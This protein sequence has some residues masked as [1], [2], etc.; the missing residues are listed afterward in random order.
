M[1]PGVAALAAWQCGGGD[2]QS[3]VTVKTRAT[4]PA[5]S[6]DDPE[7]TP[8]PSKPPEIDLSSDR[9]FQGGAALLS[10]IGDVSEGSVTFLE[11]KQ[12]LSQGA[13]SIYAFIPIDAEDPPGNHEFKVEF[14]LLSGSKG[15]ITGQIEV[16]ATRWTTDSIT[17][18]AR[19]SIILDPRFAAAEDE[20]LR[21]VYSPVSPDKLWEGG[22]IMP[23]G[24][25]VT[26]HFGEQ[27]SYNGGE[28]TGHHKGTDIGAP[29]GTPV[30]VTNNGRVVLARQLQLRGNT[31]VVDHGGGV[32]SSYAHLASFA[33]GEGEELVQGDVVG[34]LGST[35]LSTGAH[36]HWEMATG[37]I[38]VDAVRFVDGSNG[39]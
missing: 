38:P 23:T 30:S 1:V 29:E 17:L 22:W 16:M 24:G 10:L 6:L 12:V 7:A 37:G 8:T 25:P 13:R 32:M 35:G 31:V 11:R 14:K 33:V 18:P 15:S 4:L 20:M 9:L 3:L 2:G 34:L 27:R 36:L 21:G 26:T 19:L 28:I 5:D 39:F